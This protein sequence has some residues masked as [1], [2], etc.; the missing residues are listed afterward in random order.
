[1]P[2][3]RSAV[4]LAATAA[5]VLTGGVVVAAAPASAQI[6]TATAFGG[7]AY[8]S[9]GH[10]GSTF[11]SGRSAL[12]PLCTSSSGVTHTDT[13]QQSTTPQVG[14]LGNVHTSTSSH[15][16]AHTIASVSKAR[17]SASS[18]LAAQITGTAFAVTAKAARSS[19]GYALT[20]V[21]TLKA[22]KIFGMSAPTHPAANQKMSVPGVGTVVLN[23]QTRTKRDGLEQITVVALKLTVSANNT[24]GLPAGVLVISSARA[25]LHAPTHYLASGNAFGT[26]V[27]TGD[28]V[29][30]GKTA[31]TYL[32]CGG[33]G[34]ATHRNM[35]GAVSVTGFHSATTHTSGR[36][37]NTANGTKAKLTSRVNNVNLLGGVVRASTLV[38][39]ATATRTNG[40]LTRSSA[41]T[42]I[43]KLTV[44]GKTMS[45][46]RPANTKIAI[47]G[48]GTLWI[49]RVTNTAKGLHVEALQ[50]VL[51]S[52]QSGLA[53]G[54][55]ITV[56][57]TTAGIA[58]K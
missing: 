56:G 42:S 13:T 4:A 3:P 55:V 17:T 45:G 27:V 8:G 35:T 22:V 46:N 37:T 14:S 7:S 26:T 54:T 57:G 9:S 6:R 43:G 40:H 36:S 29:R 34:G 32:P 49:H 19:S 33:T 10:L 39:V 53:K 2:T 16:T 18:L 28:Q 31:P 20:G 52:A 12:V 24:V 48:I 21:T 5:V 50:L 11:K 44:N 41:G 47:A 51:S 15:K 30:S 23:K 1:M 38:S 25:S 58:K